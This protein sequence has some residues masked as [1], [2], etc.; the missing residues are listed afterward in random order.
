MGLIKEIGITKSWTLFLDRDGVINK[1]LKNDYVK[2]ID[3]FEFIM[4]VPEAIAKLN[5]IFKR[6]VVVTN[7]QGIAKGI[8]TETDLYLIHTYIEKLLKPYRA[9]IS[10]FYHAPT[11]ESEH[12][13]LRKPNT[14]MAYV[15]KEEFPD[16]EF[17]QCVIVGDSASDIRFGNRLGMITVLL[18]NGSNKSYYGEEKAKYEFQNL[19]EFTQAL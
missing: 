12:N 19:Q 6:I 4:G 10:E 15:A 9:H 2:N 5:T 14:G 7:Q 1:K 11:L 13:L 3:E 16:I 18:R 8:M 17:E